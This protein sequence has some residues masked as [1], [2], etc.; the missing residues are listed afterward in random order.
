MKQK[1]LAQLVAGVLTSVV[2]VGV[3]QAAGL[4]VSSTS[5]AREVI[6]NDTQT[7]TAPAAAWLYNGPL[8]AQGGSTT[9]QVQFHID[10]GTFDPSAT[11][12]LPPNS[13]GL[14][15]AF[16]LIDVVGGVEQ[17]QNQVPNVAFDVGGGGDTSQSLAGAPFKA[18][19]SVI[20][21]GYSS[22]LKTVWATITIWRNPASIL[23]NPMVMFNSR[24]NRIAETSAS[25][26]SPDCSD[27]PMTF[28]GL[29]SGDNPVLAQINGLATGLANT[30]WPSGEVISRTFVS[31]GEDQNCSNEPTRVF[32]DYSHFTGLTQ[33]N[34]IAAVNTNGVKLAIE[35]SAAEP[36]IVFPINLG[37]NSWL[38]T[39]DVRIAP[40]G[41]FAGTG[42]TAA[43]TD[44]T[45]FS[46][47]ATG[48][49]V[50]FNNVANLGSVWMSQ[51]GT[52]NDLNIATQYQLA[53]LTNPFIAIAASR[54]GLVEA[55]DF[56]LAITATEGFASD[57]RLWLDPDPECATGGLIPTTPNIV[58][59]NTV[60][61]VGNTAAVATELIAAAAAALPTPRALYVCYHS[62]STA[63]PPSGF[64]A[65]AILNKADPGV[66]AEADNMSCPIPLTGFSG[67]VK[68]D[69]RNYANSTN[70]N[71]YSVIRLINTSETGTAKVF[72]QII[73]PGGEFG[74]WGQIASIPPRGVQNLSAAQ[75]DAL[76]TPNMDMTFGGGNAPASALDGGSTALPYTGT[77]A[78]R[79][80]IT[81]TGVNTLRVQNYMRTP[82][83]EVHEYSSSQGVDFDGNNNRVPGTEQSIDQDARTGINGLD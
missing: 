83:G 25:G 43:V 65:R 55:T 48:A 74:P 67:G 12:G 30:L 49:G 58:T 35:S 10:R 6:L 68:I 66:D 24:L 15:Q 62:A 22:D 75:I 23:S 63:I 80:R 32:V 21:S 64:T 45:S 79:L 36:Y 34:S 1:L 56:R 42:N 50:P 76:I 54:L 71:Y 31:T 39:K 44:R 73:E 2:A 11:T 5:I 16:A 14:A 20:A 77:G 52:G 82:T 8:N 69:V 33:E 3:A 81:A 60:T 41:G 78:P 4:Q 18:Q 27:V 61:V 37:F 59:N 29:A 72:A 46:S 28:D 13:P 17:Y 9:F 70:T 19:Y 26:C 38:S 53:S 40:A 47:F 7:I 51:Q 57:A